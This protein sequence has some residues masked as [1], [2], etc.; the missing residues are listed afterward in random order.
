MPVDRAIVCGGAGEAGLPFGADCPVRLA[1]DGPDANVHLQVDDLRLP[2]VKPLSPVVLDL[3]TIAA[4]VYAGDQ[5]AA[6]G[7]DRGEYEDRW[8]RRL[9][10][11]IPVL[12]PDRWACPEVRDA[13][14]SV[15][16]FL[17]ED[18][19]RFEFVQ[20]RPERQL[21]FPVD[22]SPLDGVIEDVV[23]FSGGLDSLAGAV[24]E[25]VVDRRRVLLLNHRSTSKVA[26][27]YDDLAKSLAGYA[28]DTPPV[29]AYVRVNKDQRLSADRTQR[30][31]SF[32]FASLAAAFARM[33]GLDRVRFYE[34]GVVSLNLPLSAQVLGSRATRT[35]HPQT[36][37]GFGRLFSALFERPFAVD[38]PFLWHTKADI[39][40][41]IT[42]AGCGPLIG[43][44]SSCAET[45]ARSAE[46]PHC[47]ICSQCIDRRFA[48]LAA[49]QADNDPVT[50]Y[51]VELF[52]GPRADRGPRA[53]IAGYLETVNEVTKADPPGFFARFGEAARVV[54]H[55]GRPAGVAARSVFD[56]YQRHA[57]DVRRVLEQGLA[58]HAAR[59]IA[60]DL[61]ADCLVRMVT[62]VRAD[63]PAGGAEPTDPGSAGRPLPQGNY[64]F[65]RMGQ[66]W[67]YRYA[68]SPLGFLKESRGAEYLHHLFSN[69][70]RAVEAVTLYQIA[71]GGHAGH[72]LGSAGEQ[73][74]MQAL[75]DIRRRL[76][77]LDADRER[78]EA[79]DPVFAG[80]SQNEREQLLGQLRSG[81]GLGRRLRQ[82][83][84]DV[85][86]I[87]KSVRNAVKRAIEAIR[88]DAPMFADHLTKPHLTTG[89]DLTYMPPPDVTWET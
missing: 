33:T 47:G 44:T 57:R 87:R 56:L 26:R 85:E 53:M 27:R 72:G 2:I 19:Y 10:F 40:R 15:L 20:G 38:N 3:V 61:P 70:G 29:H 48:I 81:T 59:L 14:T 18:E 78:A 79:E 21:R 36:L 51:E 65:R 39:V 34:N 32:L 58:D 30:T 73:I 6:R 11:R 89:R 74:D 16:S 13:L 66:T 88:K 17:S 22:E 41:L 82:A 75:A 8:R 62:D 37:A 71:T 55:V 54:R 52:T 45:A 28:G 9:F 68:G 60:R 69:P 7:D 24:Q 1:L 77:D 35:T 12:E 76:A 64:V 23:L 25:A 46:Y 50:G 83:S 80:A 84:D 42:D 31:R 86:T 63:V 4:Y 67:V 43:R 5:A 49:G